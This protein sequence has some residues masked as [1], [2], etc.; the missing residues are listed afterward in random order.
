MQNKTIL[1]LAGFVVTTV[2][3]AGRFVTYKITSSPDVQ[4]SKENRK[5]IFRKHQP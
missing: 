1:P 4:I 2:A 5:Q 3:F